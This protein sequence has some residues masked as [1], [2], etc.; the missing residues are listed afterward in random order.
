MFSI[1]LPSLS[2]LSR[3]KSS[4]GVLKICHNTIYIKIYEYISLYL[5]FFFLLFASIWWLDVV[6]FLLLVAADFM[7]DISLSIDFNGE[8]SLVAPSIRERRKERMPTKTTTYTTKSILYSI[9]WMIS[10]ECNNFFFLIHFTADFVVARICFVAQQ[11]RRL[12]GTWSQAISNNR[13]A[14]RHAI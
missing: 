1:W 9:I 3:Q 12:A 4:V 7:W 8:A 10:V 11:H 5:I 13:A 2:V 14:Y 6:F